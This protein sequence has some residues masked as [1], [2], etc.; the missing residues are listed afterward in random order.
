MSLISHQRIRAE[1][2]VKRNALKSALF[3]S[4]IAACSLAAQSAPLQ[5][6]Q[7]CTTIR[8]ASDAGGG[9]RIISPPRP[10][11]YS[12]SL[13]EPVPI[14]CANRAAFLAILTALSQNDTTIAKTMVSQN[15]CFGFKLGEKVTIKDKYTLGAIAIDCLEA[16]GSGGCRW[17]DAGY[18]F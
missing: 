2:Q 11:G 10:I 8:C 15:D 13:K 18:K 6:Q 9:M 5:A 17:T 4:I 14:A 12:G 1:I 7:T 3:A 16:V